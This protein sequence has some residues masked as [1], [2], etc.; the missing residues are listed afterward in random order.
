MRDAAPKSDRNKRIV[1]TIVLVVLLGFGSIYVIGPISDLFMQLNI[2]LKDPERIRSFIDNFGS[3]APVVFMGIQISQ[4]LLAPIPG[5]AT[6]FIGGFLFG[7]LAGF[8][9][10][11][12]GLSIGSWLN[13][14]I[15]RFLGERFVRKWIPADIFRRYDALL[16]RQGILVILVLFLFPGFPKDYL[17][18]FLGLSTLPTK[19]FLILATFGRMPG[20][21]AL[22][23][24]GA[25]LF[26]QD[27]LLLVALAGIC[28]LA[29]LVAYRF[30]EHMYQWAEKFNNK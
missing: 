15:G 9:Y 24:Q 11:S 30:R 20:T 25:L 17:S 3:W 21:F 12:I 23:L 29:A 10:S 16:K 19:L 4:V 5:E 18:L 13:F 14:L 27:D 26:E 28:A 6:G 1:L 22:S 2:W 8:F 7:T